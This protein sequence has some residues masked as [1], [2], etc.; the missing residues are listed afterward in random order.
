MNNQEVQNQ[1]LPEK[2]N[3]DNFEPERKKF[4]LTEELRWHKANRLPV[5]LVIFTVILSLLAGA[6]GGA[7]GTF[8]LYRLPQFQKYLPAGQSILPLNQKVNFTEDSAVIDVTKKASPA[9]VS[10]IISKN[11][12]QVPGFGFD[13][14]APF[15]G[16]NNNSSGNGQDIGSSTLQQVGAGSG[17]LISSDGLILT[18]KHVVSD[19]S[20]SYSVITSDGKS[21]DATVSSRDP[22][23]D[24]AIIK[25]NIKDA[26]FLT[27]A[28]SSQL[29]IGQRVIAI[30]NSLGQYQNTVTTG[31][32]SGIGRSITAGSSDGTEQL[33]GVI[34]TDAAINPG[35]SGGPLLNIAGQV[36]GINTAIDQQGQLVGFAIPS[37]DV[38]RALASFQ[39]YG[40][41]TR[42]FLGIRYIMLTPAIAQS[43]KLPKDY[44]ALILRGS[45]QTDLAVTPGSPAEKAGLAENDIVLEINGNKLDGNNTLSDAL[46]NN[47]V[48][49]TVTLKVYHNGVEKMVKVTLGEAK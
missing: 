32:V 30:G 14:F 42:P 37:S 33:S 16:L 11:L 35:N 17:F 9:V 21:Y 28:D 41:I 8:Y 39:K 23:N 20:A 47:N 3:K 12:S 15:F 7:I 49:D 31:I 45:K 38:S 43:E 36:V 22:V 34:Q 6:V 25:I 29:Q 24:L 19:S 5:F 13:P 2:P 1:I 26:P 44:G 4:A 10:I 46:K 48:G 27:L 40:H 18:N